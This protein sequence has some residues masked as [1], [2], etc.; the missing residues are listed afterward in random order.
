MIM[1]L[2]GWQGTAAWTSKGENPTCEDVAT[3]YEHSSEWP[4]LLERILPR[5]EHVGADIS[6]TF[7]T[8]THL[9]LQ[10][11]Y[12]SF[13]TPTIPL[14][15]YLPP[16]LK[17]EHV[18]SKQEP[19]A[20]KGPSDGTPPSADEI[21]DMNETQSGLGTQTGIKR[22][23]PPSLDSSPTKRGR[24]TSPNP[25]NENPPCTQIITAPPNTLPP[26]LLSLLQTIQATL[27]TTFATNPPHTAQ[28]LA[29]LLLH[30]NLHY[31]TLPSYLRALDRIVS[32]A[33]PASAFPLPNI[34]PRTD[35]NGFMV[36]GASSPTPEPGAE[37][38]FIGGA[39]LTEIPWLGNRGGGESPV[40]SGL[41]P[42]LRTESTRLIDGPNGAGSVET[43]TV[44]VNGVSN[45]TSHSDLSHGI[46]QGELLR[47]EQEAGIVPVPSP[48]HNGRVTRSSAAATAAATRT[49][50]GED[51]EAGGIEEDEPVHARGPDVI[52]MEDMGPQPL[53]SGL[54]GGLDLEGA[55]G[56][57]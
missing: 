45:H 43:V 5:L 36:N 53:G 25:E 44:N 2:P 33:S 27:S 39:E 22:D 1:Y 31:R 56:R 26:L 9:S 30:P 6:W 35:T 7:V 50:T 32:V 10:I 19:L 54:A 16:L 37:N 23:L 40:H 29:E 52:G 42:D 3:E 47:Q 51:E 24:N 17:E 20:K 55:L 57:R 11:A 8:L 46:T 4:N 14:S 38:N 49:V 13:P 28:R 34:H 18:A 15:N 41:G 21:M 12:N 48:A